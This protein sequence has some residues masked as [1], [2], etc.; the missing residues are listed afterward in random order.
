MTEAMDNGQSWD[1]GYRPWAE[2]VRRGKRQRAILEYT[3]L[4]VGEAS[5]AEQVRT[6]KLGIQPIRCGRAK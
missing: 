2:Q 4:P 6:D 5:G 1:T 3:L